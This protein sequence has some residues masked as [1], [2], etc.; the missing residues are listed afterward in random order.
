MQY[1]CTFSVHR[2]SA[3]CAILTGCIQCS[4]F[5]QHGGGYGQHGGDHGQHGG[6]HGQHGGD[7]GR[8][9]GL[10]VDLRQIFVRSQ[11]H[12]RLRQMSLTFAF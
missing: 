12:V 2:K 7:H 3:Q 4:T 10:V 11:V 8:H 6:D 1:T 9:G 5:A